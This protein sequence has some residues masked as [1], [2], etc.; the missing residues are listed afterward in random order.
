[1]QPGC[2]NFLLNWKTVVTTTQTW[3]NLWKMVSVSRFRK[4][5]RQTVNLGQRPR[6]ADLV[7][8]QAAEVKVMETA[9][10]MMN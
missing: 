8:L 4:K 7:A 3:H 5:L 1:M 6:D 2:Q 9:K 10:G